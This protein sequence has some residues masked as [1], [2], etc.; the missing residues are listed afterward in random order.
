M[1]S[2]NAQCSRGVIV[3]VQ[4]GAVKIYVAAAEALW[5]KIDRIKLRKWFSEFH[6]SA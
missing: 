2:F 4:V 1:S 5:T 6:P 3:A